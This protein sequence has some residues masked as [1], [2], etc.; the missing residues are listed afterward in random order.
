MSPL[1][2][3]TPSLILIFASSLLSACG[4]GG[5]SDGSNPFALSPGTPTP[6]PAPAPAPTPSTTPASTASPSPTLTPT[7]TPAPA[8]TP[9]AS[10]LPSVFA[11]FKTSDSTCGS[12]VDVFL[13]GSTVVIQSNAIPNHG[14][15]YFAVGNSCRESNSTAGFNQNPNQI[16]S[17]NLTFR[18]PVSPAEA[19][20]KQATPGGPIGVSIN[21]VPF[22][23][24]YAAGGSP[25]TN[26]I[27]SFDQYGGHPQQ[28]GQY[29]Y[30]VEPK[31][32]TTSDGRNGLMGFLLDGFPV[33]GPMENG[34]LVSE[35]A[36]DDYHGHIAVTADYPNGIYHY[37]ITGSDPY[38]NG[39][40]FYGSPGTVS[41]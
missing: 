6:S 21:G 17:A 26:E 10:S 14:S 41:Q 29:H 39:N 22:F 20:A 30:H 18:I 27:Q 7:A 1:P 5:V 34:A 3:L 2:S 9:S 25:L 24:Q 35:S 40:G 15:P 38:I 19:S 4:G 11:K 37:H 13:D 8:P 31:S 12:S 28:Q 33:Y 32:L 23:N 36:L 16:A